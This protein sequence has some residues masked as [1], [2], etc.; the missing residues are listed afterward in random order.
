M[1][2]AKNAL[3]IRFISIPS[4]NKRPITLNGMPNFIRGLA[5]YSDIFGFFFPRKNPKIKKGIIFIK[6]E[7]MVLIKYLIKQY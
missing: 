4:F 3:L 7:K 6:R 1:E 5:I 2:N